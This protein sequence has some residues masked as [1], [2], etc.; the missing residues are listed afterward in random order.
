MRLIIARHAQAEDQ[1][2]SDA[3]RKLTAEGRQQAELLGKLLAATLPAVDEVWTSPLVRCRET[4]EIAV[5]A[6]G[7]PNPPK[8]LAQLEP[9]ADPETL[10]ALAGR[11]KL[12][13]LM[14]VGHAPDVGLLAAH[15]L[16]FSSEHHLKKGA[17]CIVEIDDPVRPPGRAVATLEAKQYPSILRGET[18]SPWMRTRLTV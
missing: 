5:K 15:L 9:G 18:Y 3:A 14:L 8:S 12:G 7:R 10:T 4:A 13:S 1:A 17:V 2:A 6:M 16:G 11:S